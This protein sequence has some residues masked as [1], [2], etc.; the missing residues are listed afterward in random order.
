MTRAFPLIGEGATFLVT[1][2]AGF[3]GRHLC[4]RLLEMGHSVVCLDNLSTGSLFNISEFSS[5]PKFRL[6][7]HDIVLPFDLETIDGIFHLACPASPIQYQA[8]PIETTKTSVLGTL[9]LLELALKHQVPLLFTSTSEVYGDPAV[10]PQPESYF[11]NVNCT[12][13]RACYDEGK[14]CAESLCYDF[15]RV[16]GVSVKVARL[17]NCYG[18]YMAQDDGR[19]MSNFVYQAL[20]GAPI[21]IYGDG[22]QT[23]SFCYVSDT[24]DGLISLASSSY[25]GPVN[26]GNPNEIT[27]QTLV[28]NIIEQTN[29]QSPIQH[30]VLP[31]DDPKRRCPDITL[32]LTEL[33]WL[34]K[35]S[36]EQ[37]IRKVIDYYSSLIHAR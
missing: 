18:P 33:A 13:P 27:M 19:A 22:Q 24:V 17:F 4:Q 30:A 12:G 23:R 15:A 3:I 34:P 5:H 28:Q 32:A 1:G 29:S 20:T 2:G 7:Q 37:G 36:L 10:S 35:V 9:N 26:I 11:G 25:M 16:H 6:L 21:T 14:R 8:S 31:I